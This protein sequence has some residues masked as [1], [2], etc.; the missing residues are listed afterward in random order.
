METTKRAYRLPELSGMQVAV[1][2]LKLC[3]AISHKTSVKL[4]RVGK[5]IASVMETHAEEIDTIRQKLI[6]QKKSQT[7]EQDGS[8]LRF[9]PEETAEF[10]REVSNLAK[11]PIELELPVLLSKDFPED[12]KTLGTRRTAKQDSGGKVFEVDIYFYD[13]YIALLGNLIDD[14]A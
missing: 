4:H 5:I 11:D 6:E 12:P 9:T 14:E 13:H 2:V 1:D 8:K 3:P 7:G 10:N